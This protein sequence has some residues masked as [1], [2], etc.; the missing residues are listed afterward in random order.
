MGTFLLETTTVNKKEKGF[1]F[2]DIHGKYGVIGKEK[3][4][5]GCESVTV[6]LTFISNGN[7]SEFSENDILSLIMDKLKE[8]KK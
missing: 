8:L 4:F 1:Y 2:E 6:E 3:V 7:T 5:N